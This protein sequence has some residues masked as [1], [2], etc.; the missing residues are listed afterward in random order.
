VHLRIIQWRRRKE[1]R[2]NEKEIRMESEIKGGL[3][4]TSRE[5]EVHKIF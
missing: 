2:R 1:E 5:L 3:G 4:W